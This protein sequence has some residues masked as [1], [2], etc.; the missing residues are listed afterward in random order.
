MTQAA[1]RISPPPVGSDA[2]L[3]RQE[4]KHRLAAAFRIFAALG[5][6]F[7]LAGHAVFRDPEMADHFWINPF[8]VDW[9]LITAADLMLVDLE[10]TVADG[11]DGAELNPAG[12]YIHGS[13]LR[14]RADVNCS[15]HAHAPA[16]VG[17]STKSRLLPPSAQDM[18]SFYGDHAVFDEYNAAVDAWEEGDKIARA[19][20]H[21]KVVILRNHGIVS[22]GGSVDSAAWWF[23]KFERCCQV[24]LSVEASGNWDEIDPVAAATMASQGGSDAVGWR[25]FQPL[26]ERALAQHPDLRS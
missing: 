2:E 19:L 22:V 6:D 13:I 5:F 9:A 25:S 14:E 8:G 18:C 11:P 15:V 24:Q 21:N 17:W 7:G 16:S 12:L 23:I 26:Y 4:G 20:G 3:R 10:G 1:F